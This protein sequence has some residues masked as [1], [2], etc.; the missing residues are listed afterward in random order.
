MAIPAI[1]GIGAALIG[2]RSQK[3]AASSAAA[4]QTQ[5]SEAGIAET[6]RQF[7]EQMRQVG[8]AREALQPFTDAGTSAI[9]AQLALSGLS[10]PDAERAAIQRIEG[11]E[12]F[13][14]LTRAGEEGILQSA[15]ATGGLRGGN[16][17]AALAQ[18]RPQVLSSLINQQFSNLGG[19]A[20]IGQ[21]SAAGGIPL[22][23]L[24]GSAA[25]GAGSQISGLL[26]QQGAAQAGGALASGQASAN[27][28]S[29][30]AGGL[31][32]GFG[33]TGGGG[34]GSN[35]AFNPLFGGSSNLGIG[36]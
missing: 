28:A 10:G 14:A 22:A 13:Q 20:G 16:T 9:G 17:Q 35:P 34:F 33:N 1:L 36:F 23:N 7:D 12:Q 3:K 2:S 8:I 4:S 6:R 26:A 5:A 27:L 11:G 21:A 18:F 30:V 19:I 24:A 32:Q 29:Q 15:S 31:A 25:Q